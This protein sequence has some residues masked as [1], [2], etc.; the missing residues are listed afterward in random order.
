MTDCVPSDRNQL[1]NSFHPSPALSGQTNKDD[2]DID[3][4]LSPNQDANGEQQASDARVS[5]KWTRKLRQM[6]TRVTSG[7]TGRRV[8]YFPRN[9][10]DEQLLLDD[11]DDR[12]AERVT[13]R[14]RAVTKNAKERC[15]AD[16]LTSVNERHVIDV[17]YEYF[18]LQEKHCRLANE[19]K[20]ASVFECDQPADDVITVK[21]LRAAEFQTMFRSFEQFNAAGVTVTSSAR[22]G[23]PDY[24]LSSRNKCVP[25]VCFSFSRLRVGR[26]RM[27]FLRKVKA[28]NFGAFFVKNISPDS[29][30]RLT[31]HPEKPSTSKLGRKLKVNTI[32]GQLMLV[33]KFQN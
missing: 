15:F 32:S 9:D 5:R 8:E 18:L 29:L 28:R 17:V 11:C 14:E 21:I 19:T 6:W 20:P 7:A 13:S 10:D 26:F 22:S 24:F 31:F 12:P 25:G 27:V 2:N 30:L 16:V 3:L 23:A 1:T 4:L 33:P